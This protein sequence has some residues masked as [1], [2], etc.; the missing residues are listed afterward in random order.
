MA[1]CA[2][3]NGRGGSPRCD[4]SGTTGGMIGGVCPD[5]PGKQ[6]MHAWHATAPDAGRCLSQ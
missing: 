5:M 3:C 2:T 4:G 1:V 6:G